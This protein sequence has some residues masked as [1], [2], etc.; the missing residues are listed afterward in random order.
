MTP[1]D[2]PAVWRSKAAEL[3]DFGAFVQ[4]ALLERVAG[5]LESALRDEADA[6][7]TLAEAAAESGYS[8]RRLREL[9]AEGAIP[10]AGAR[11][12]PRIRRVDLPR[13]ARPANTN[14]DYDAQADALRL[15]ATKT[16]R[17]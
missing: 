2:L 17:R 4:A 3:R 7:L 11:G 1:T 8:D 5:E 12:R 15:L 13:R 10:N 6:A 16:G 14:G 9:I